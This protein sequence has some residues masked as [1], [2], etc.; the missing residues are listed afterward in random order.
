MPSF[1]FCCPLDA[2]RGYGWGTVWEWEEVHDVPGDEDPDAALH[3]HDL[4]LPVRRSR[5]PRR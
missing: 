5:W 3:L 2:A 1:G 4:Q